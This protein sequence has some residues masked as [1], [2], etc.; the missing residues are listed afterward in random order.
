MDN[1]V[2]ALIPNIN[3]PA[4]HQ[5]AGQESEVSSIRSASPF[6]PKTPEPTKT[7]RKEY[8][9]YQALEQ[10]VLGHRVTRKDWETGDFCFLK[11]EILSICRDGKDHQWII[12]LGDIAG[13]D[14]IT[15][16]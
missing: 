11:Q 1:T 16:D 8:T 12:S 3:L 6:V 15:L 4:N 13:S 9:F 14:W 10:I 7:E 2:D 5:D